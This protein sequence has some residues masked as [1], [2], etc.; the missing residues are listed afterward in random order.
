MNQTSSILS[1]KNFS[2]DK[3]KLLF[4][5]SKISNLDSIVEGGFKSRFIGATDSENDEYAI[6]IDNIG[7]FFD[8]VRTFWT[9]K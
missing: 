8:L 2:I 6:K 1:K 3:V 5:A 4:H 7:I 9:P